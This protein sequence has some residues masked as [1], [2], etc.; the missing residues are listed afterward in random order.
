MH[1]TAHNKS[2]PLYVTRVQLGGARIHGK[3]SRNMSVRPSRSRSD[4]RP[5]YAPVQSGKS[6]TVNVGKDELLV[7]G[8]STDQLR[9]ALATAAGRNV[10]KESK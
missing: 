5:P 4:T 7:I 1:I 3:I 10:V 9:N 2:Q 8:S 6:R